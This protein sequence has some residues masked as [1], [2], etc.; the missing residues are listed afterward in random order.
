MFCTLL[1]EV[2]EVSKDSMK[3]AFGFRAY[4]NIYDCVPSDFNVNSA[5]YD[6]PGAN[7]YK[8]SGVS[9]VFLRDDALLILHRFIS[10]MISG[11]RK[12]NKVNGMEVYLLWCAQ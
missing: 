12:V 7:N 3:E 11:K 10:Y 9:S 5:W 1:G 6:L 8:T 4:R 2:C